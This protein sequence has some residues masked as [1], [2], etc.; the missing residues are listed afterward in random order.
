MFSNAYQNYPL[1]EIWD[2]KSNSHSDSEANDKA[3]IH[4]KLFKVTPPSL[5]KQYNK[6]VKSY[7]FELASTNSKISLPANSYNELS[8]YYRMLILQLRIPM[9]SHWSL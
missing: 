7:I 5:K 1:L 6:E 8:I 3:Q 2:S 4:E 9:G